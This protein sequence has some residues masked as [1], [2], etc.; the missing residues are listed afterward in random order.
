MIK[1]FS[2]IIFICTILLNQIQ[3]REE[4]IINACEIE[5]GKEGDRE[6]GR[7]IEFSTMYMYTVFVCK[8]LQVYL[9]ISIQ[10]CMF[11]FFRK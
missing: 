6:K 4:H 2:A 10:N 7:K 3:I 9:I 5:R 1:T 8:H 11:Q